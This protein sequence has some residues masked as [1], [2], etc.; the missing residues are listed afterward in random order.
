MLERLISSVSAI[1]HQRRKPDVHKNLR[2]ASLQRYR[3]DNSPVPLAHI[4]QLLTHFKRE[5]A[6]ALLCNEL[7][8]TLGLGSA[9]WCACLEK[10]QLKNVRLML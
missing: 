9:K 5:P 6:S 2:R 8:F 10:A 3:L 7:C 4:L 1:F